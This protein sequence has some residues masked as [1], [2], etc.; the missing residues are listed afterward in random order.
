VIAGDWYCHSLGQDS[1][2]NTTS[3]W[4]RR[5]GDIGFVLSD[6][7]L[8]LLAACPQATYTFMQSRPEILNSWLEEVEQLSGFT[9]SPKQRQEREITLSKLVESI[10][11]KHPVQETA[12]VRPRILKRL[13]TMCVRAVDET[14]PKPPCQRVALQ[15]KP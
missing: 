7:F 13:E 8:L 2:V 6:Q 15:S 14:P 9:V 3:Q 4:Q 12:E 10:K 5:D 11:R 1:L